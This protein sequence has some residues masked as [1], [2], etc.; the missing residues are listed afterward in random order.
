MVSWRRGAVGGLTRCTWWSEPAR[1][2]HPRS[3]SA[4]RGRPWRVRAVRC[5]AVRAA[6]AC[7]EAG[8][9]A[10]AAGEERVR[11][12]WRGGVA[13]WA[14]WWGCLVA[15]S[16]RLKRQVEVSFFFW[17]L[18]SCSLLPL[19]ARRSAGE[20][21]V[22]RIKHPSHSDVYRG[23]R[24][25]RPRRLPWPDRSVRA[26]CAPLTAHDSKLQWLGVGVWQQADLP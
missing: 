11:R 21:G 17:K 6:V 20:D 26:R 5:G 13:A 4:S 1:P 3:G 19:R 9:R 22:R 23:V 7:V 12:R 15:S 16:N 10:A 2:K 14:A 24:L 25:W 18:S 8:G